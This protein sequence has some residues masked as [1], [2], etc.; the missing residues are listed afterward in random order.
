MFE[1]FFADEDRVLAHDHFE[2]VRRRLIESLEHAS[3]C[4]WLL[5]V[6]LHVGR[7]LA[8]A[9][10]I[11]GPACQDR[12]SGMPS[13]GDHSGKEHSRFDSSSS[14]PLPPALPIFGDARNTCAHF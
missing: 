2:P 11:H 9:R 12:L 7:E 6:T 3:R 10:L 4:A 1:P 8:P 14:G 5:E 13:R